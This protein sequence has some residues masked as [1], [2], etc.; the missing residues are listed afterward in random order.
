MEEYER[1]QQEIRELQPEA[2]AADA[3]PWGQDE[4]LP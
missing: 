4:A 3:Q 1:L 2:V